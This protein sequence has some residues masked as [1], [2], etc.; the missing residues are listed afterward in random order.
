MTTRELIQKLMNCSMDAEIVFD[1]GNSSL[2]LYEVE[3][4]SESD[5]LV[6]IKCGK[7]HSTKLLPTE[8]QLDFIKKIEGLLKV[9][10]EGGTKQDA[11]K[12][13]NDNIDRFRQRQRDLQFSEMCRNYKPSK[14]EVEQEKWLEKD[15]ERR[16]GP[17]GE[18]LDPYEYE[19]DPFGDGFGGAPITNP[20]WR[21]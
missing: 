21:E 9:K 18:P 12:F 10:F 20:Y 14:F 3:G 5:S 8:K 19:I 7:V 17:Y 2:H 1:G 4:V 6:T 16:S 11:W 15:R 13:I